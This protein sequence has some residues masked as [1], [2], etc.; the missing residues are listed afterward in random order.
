MSLK[1]S[2]SATLLPPPASSEDSATED[3]PL[4]G[5]LEKYDYSDTPVVVPRNKYRNDTYR[6]CVTARCIVVAHLSYF[7]VALLVAH[8]RINCES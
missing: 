8:L 7:I 4:A 6:V 1:S 5:V 2:V 3:L